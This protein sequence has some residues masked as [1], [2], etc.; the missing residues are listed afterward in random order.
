MTFRAT[1][2]EGA[3]KAPARDKARRAAAHRRA[4][5]TARRFGGAGRIARAPSGFGKHK[6]HQHHR[7]IAAPRPVEARL[8]SALRSLYLPSTKVRSDQPDS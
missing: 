2:C 5:S 3:C 4:A 6:T 1:G 8:L 7:R